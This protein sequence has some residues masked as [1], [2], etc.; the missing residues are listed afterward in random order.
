LR[1]VAGQRQSP[2]CRFLTFEQINEHSDTEDNQ[3]LLDLIGAR[4][5]AGVIVVNPVTGILRLP[6]FAK[7]GVPVVTINST[8]DFGIPSVYPDLAAFLP[9]ALDCLVARGRRRVAIITNARLDNPADQLAR[10]GD[11]LRERGLPVEPAW[12]Q[13]A[14]SDVPEWS[15]QLTR[16]LLR[17]PASERPDALVITDDN[18]VPSITA[19]IA[20]Q[21]DVVAHA[22]FPRPTPSAVPA[23][24]V[25]YDLERLLTLCL[26]RLAQQ[27]RGEETPLLTTIEPQVAE[28]GVAVGDGGART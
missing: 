5:L 17:G 11:L 14:H 2:T 28:T 7:S 19:G 22:N 24:R 27:R 6:P 8:S 12:L 1:T 18:L 13:A 10:F 9:L 4:R 23:Q 26:E 25:G 20:G 15:R 3:R 16:L 21:L